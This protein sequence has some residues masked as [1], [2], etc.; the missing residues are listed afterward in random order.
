MSELVCR[1][2]DLLAESKGAFASGVKNIFATKAMAT[3]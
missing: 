2:L 3:L 1:T